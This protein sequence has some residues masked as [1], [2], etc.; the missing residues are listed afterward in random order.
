[1]CQIAGKLPHAS[2]LDG[3][4]AVAPCGQ[5]G[6]TASLLAEKRQT[7]PKTDAGLIHVKI[8]C[9]VHVCMRMNGIRVVPNRLVR[10]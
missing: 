9:R 2:G 1:M 3:Q 6:R 8:L 4:L 10:S 7:R 5:S